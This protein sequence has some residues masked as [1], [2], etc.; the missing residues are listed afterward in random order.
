M[1]IVGHDRYPAASASGLTAQIGGGMSSIVVIGNGPS[2]KGFDLAALGARPS[3]GMNAAYR[4][5]DRIGWYPTYYACLDDIVVMSHADAISNMVREQRCRAF[6]LH[7]NILE[8]H[9]WLETRPDVFFLE[10]FIDGPVVDAPRRKWNIPQLDCRMFW[11]SAAMKVTTGSHAVR[12]ARYLGYTDILLLGIDASYVQVIDQA[13]ENDGRLTIARTPDSNPNYFFD[14]YQQQGDVYNRPTPARYGDGNFHADAFAALADEW[15]DED[16]RITIGTQQSE[17]Y[18]RGIFPYQDPTAA[19]AAPAESP[20]PLPDRNA[21]QPL[22]PLVT[23]PTR[24]LR[25]FPNLGVARVG[26]DLWHWP[27]EAQGFEKGSLAFLFAEPSKITGP[28]NA[29]VTVCCSGETTARVRL[30]RFGSTKNEYGETIID[31]Q[32]GDTTCWL[33]ARFAQEHDAIKLTIELEPPTFI[34]RFDGPE[35]LHLRVK[36]VTLAAGESGA[37][38]LLGSI[39]KPV[40]PI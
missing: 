29:T 26:P 23:P 24:F 34:S 11:H 5:W 1:A 12:F 3:L 10:A 30:G 8:R 22:A 17:L 27:P 4:H 31:L 7:A 13:A 37:D 21:P 32:R 38:A 14:D 28:F 40:H 16:V 19:L 20:L 36:R 25:T 18:R 9:P 2:L 35:S 33:V 39:K 6:F 15:H